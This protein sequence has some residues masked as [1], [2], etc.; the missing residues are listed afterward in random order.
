MR[1]TPTVRLRSTILAA[2][3]VG[4]VLPFGAPARVADAAAPL[5]L[6]TLPP[7]GPTP[8]TPVDADDIL[9][10]YAPGTSAARR[11]AIEREHG[12]VARRD[13]E[14]LSEEAQ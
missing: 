11:A 4:L 10:R 1:P 6:P 3:V 2:L 13:Q 12:L 7:S 5:A 14:H 9:V 8:P